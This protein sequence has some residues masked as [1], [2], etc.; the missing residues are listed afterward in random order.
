M[1]N[2]LYSKAPT[3]PNADALLA[4]QAEIDAQPEGATFWQNQQRAWLLGYEGDDWYQ[5]PEPDDSRVD[6]LIASYSED[7][8][9]YA[10]LR[11]DALV[12][13][14][15][16]P[17]FV[18]GALVKLGEVYADLSRQIAAVLAEMPDDWYVRLNALK[19]ER[20]SLGA[21]FYR[22]VPRAERG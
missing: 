13:R 22:D 12:L 19:R 8:E 17:D 14:R 15:W 20:R 9:R 16:A 5:Y 10:A 21:Q 3:H 7:P 11:F 1:T 18:D 6:A 2:T 4:L